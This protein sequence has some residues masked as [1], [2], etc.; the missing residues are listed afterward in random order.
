[1]P[2]A[3]ADSGERIMKRRDELDAVLSEIENTIGTATDIPVDLM[4]AMKDLASE[5]EVDLDAP[6]EGDVVI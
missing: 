1:V 3:F 4:R 5:I 2:V 6:I